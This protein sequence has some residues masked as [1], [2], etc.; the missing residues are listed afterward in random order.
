MEERAASTIVVG[1]LVLFLIGLAGV[2]LVSVVWAPYSFVT[3]LPALFFGSVFGEGTLFLGAAVGSLVVPALYAWSARYIL[4]KR[5]PL[6]K[7]SIVSFVTLALLS[8]T[9]AIYGWEET[10]RYTFVTRA[11][12]LVIQSVVPPIVIAV[13]ALVLRK[14]LTPEMSIK[15]HWAAFAWIAWSAFPWYGELL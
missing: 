1:A 3:V 12:A 11:V 6:P 8:F 2:G 9:Y 10:I 14:R 5:K 13:V 15:L 7:I 4:K